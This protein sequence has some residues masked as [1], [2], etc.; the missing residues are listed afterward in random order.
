MRLKFWD[1]TPSCS[2][3]H[4]DATIKR[5]DDTLVDE[6][7]CFICLEHMKP[8]D[9][10]HPLMCQNCHFNLCCQCLEMLYGSATCPN[11]RS[12]IS[13]TIGDTILLRKVDDIDCHLEWCKPIMSEPSLLKEIANSRYREAK[14]WTEIEC[15]DDTEDSPVDDDQ[16]HG[17]E[18]D[19]RVG[20]HASI[21]L[22]VEKDEL[23]DNFSHKID[24]S[25]LAGVESV[26]SVREQETIT[27]LFTSGDP[28][29]LAMAASAL[30]HIAN[31]VLSKQRMSSLADNDTPSTLTELSIY[32]LIQDGKRARRG[33]QQKR[34]APKQ[35]YVKYYTAKA[36]HFRA[37]DRQVQRQCAKLR[38][39][40]LPSRMPKTIKAVDSLTFCDS[41]W[42]GTLQDAYSQRSSAGLEFQCSA[43]TMMD[44]NTTTLIRIDTPRRR[45][46]L[47]NAGKQGEC[48]GDVVTHVNGAPIAFDCAADLQ[49][50]LKANDS[51][52]ITLNADVA[53]AESLKRRHAALR[54]QRNYPF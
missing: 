11:C 13:H 50:F 16:E 7:D 2:S 49:A 20:P 45:I 41:T 30:A 10:A 14:F 39:F 28:N 43:D 5:D 46:V 34:D 47:A 12:N 8:T 37:T 36:A 3:L 29:E 40:P 4:H 22:P 1:K 6:A 15:R 25:L 23:Y 44:N 19:V 35:Q 27:R 9:L 32:E 48:P 31:T 54:Q 26:M 53:V 17:F 18:V 21:K 24:V 51:V 38:L 42:D 52:M 33:R